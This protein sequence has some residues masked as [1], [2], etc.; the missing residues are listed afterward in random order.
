[1][2]GHQGAEGIRKCFSEIRRTFLYEEISAKSIQ[3]IYIPTFTGY[4]TR[5]KTMRRV[6]KILSG[7]A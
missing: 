2:Y 3:K 7:I 1:M 5:L 6:R 4:H